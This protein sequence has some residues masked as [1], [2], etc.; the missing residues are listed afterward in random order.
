MD[1]YEDGSVTESVKNKKGAK[2]KKGAIVALYNGALGI[3]AGYLLTDI[4]IIPKIAV[5]VTTDKQSMITAGLTATVASLLRKNFNP[6]AAVIAGAA[7]VGVISNVLDKNADPLY[8][9]N[10]KPESLVQTAEA[11]VEPKFSQFVMG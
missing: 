2:L 8:S 9:Q 10:S 1:D 4:N 3:A 5:A 11:K 6:K 7:T